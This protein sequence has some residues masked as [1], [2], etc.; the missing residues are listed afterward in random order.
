[1]LKQK[2][3][4][5][6]IYRSI[7]WDLSLK[8]FKAKYSG[9]FL[10]IWWAV[11]IPLLLTVCI[12]FVFSHLYKVNIENFA[13]FILAGMVPWI[14]FSNALS[15]AT[16]SFVGNSSLLK[17]TIFPR[18]FIPLSTAIANFLNF[19]LGFLFLLPLFIVL[20]PKVILIT[21]LFILVLFFH[22]LFL[23]GLSLFFS[24]LDIFF[25]DLSHF[26]S[27]A[28]MMWFW[29]TPV[30]YSID[31]LDFSY[32]WI[33]LMNPVSYYTI[34]YQDILF[35]AISPR[36]SVIGTAFSLGVFFFISGYLFFLKLEVKL[37]KRL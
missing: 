25:R 18:E 33:P 23:A 13:L 2:L 21:P 24:T 10:G 29:I 20:H 19:G 14:F 28:F 30:F 35:K 4:K 37:L 6:F 1:M 27:I 11:I 32:R 16:T 31:M 22:F 3:T 17:Q 34:L 12:D 5:A 26:L 36:L 15:E 9:S 7:L 8:Q